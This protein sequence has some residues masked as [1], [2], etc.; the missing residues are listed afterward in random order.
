M[1]TV[2]RA[3]ATA[4]GVD[5]RH[6]RQDTTGGTR[7]GALGTV[8]Y[9]APE[10]LERPQEAT[11][12]ADVYGLGMT[13]IFGLSG[14]ELSLSTFRNPNPTIVGLDC[15]TAVQAVLRK[16][17][18]WEPDA[19]FCDALGFVEELRSALSQPKWSMPAVTVVRANSATGVP[20]RRR[21]TSPYSAIASRRPF[22]QR[23][24]AP[25]VTAITESVRD[26][27]ELLDELLARAGAAVVDDHP[28][29]AVAAARDEHGL[30]A[31][32]EVSGVQQRM[33]WIPPGTFMMGSPKTERGRDAGEGPQHRV[34]LTRGYW[35]GETPVTQALWTPVMGDN[36]SRFRG[37][38]PD[39]LQRPVEQVSWVACQAF[40]ESLNAQVAGLAAR[41]P[42]EAQWEYACRAGTRGATWVRELSGGKST[43][44]L[45]TIAWY[46]RNS[47]GTTHH[48]GRKAPN[49]YGLFDML[50]N[51]WEWCADER[52]EYTAARR[53]D[54]V[55]E[56]RG[57]LRVYRG[58]S[59][60]VSAKLLRAANRFAFWR[61]VGNDVIGF[62]LA[63][64]E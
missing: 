47:G 29:W 9:A 62:R 53:I 31:T 43:A 22:D 48:V 36:P 38:R 1:P 27:R 54:P 4:S 13:A 61:E 23:L 46:K 10:C 64:G 34:T 42:T 59:W 7:T 21:P 37:D 57:S 41:L 8:V 17:V 18:A 60:Y 33:R 44:E 12:R 24:P 26:A 30:W 63:G 39:D 55:G 25:P 56:K 50:G 40:C 58:G 19:R 28:R 11:A 6:V 52:R 51:V 35:L 14:R 3:T 49:P 15:A 16:A 20:E 2:R 5:I 45:D 32:F